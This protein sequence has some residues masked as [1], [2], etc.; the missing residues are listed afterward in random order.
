MTPKTRVVSNDLIEK[1][2]PLVGYVVSEM[3][4]R[5]PMVE[6]DEIVSSGMEGLV[7]AAK[8]WDPEAGTQF[9]TWAR[10][11]IRWSIQEFMQSMDWMG[12][13]TRDRTK[14]LRAARE[15]LVVSLGRDPSVKEL[16]SSMGVDEH[17]VNKSISDPVRSLIPMD[18]TLHDVV[19][20]SANGP[21]QSIVEAERNLML[22]QAVQSLPVRTKEVIVRH[23]FGGE[24]QGDV[25]RALGVSDATV[26]KEKMRGLK[27][28][29]EALSGALLMRPQEPV[30]ASVPQDD[31]RK[32]LSM[33]GG[34]MA[35]GIVTYRP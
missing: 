16:A 34:A 6:R 29:Q 31:L 32:F 19:A 25:A 12:R 11:K 13:R 35:G 3:H 15:S 27:L 18:D 21:E 23:Y 24:A 4:S 5:Y 33:A 17:E 26:S 8:T 1:N 14:R 20:H 10:L 9:S 7:L 28:L 22:H 2:I 30:K